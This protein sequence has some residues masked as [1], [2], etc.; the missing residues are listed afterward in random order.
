[1]PLWR[2]AT[3][4]TADEY[5]LMLRRNKLKLPRRLAVV[6]LLAIAA[7]LAVFAFGNHEDL[8]QQGSEVQF[9]APSRLMVFGAAT[10]GLGALFLVVAAIAWMRNR[11]QRA[12]IP[13]A[14]A[15]RLPSA[16]ARG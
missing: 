3:D 15:H 13:P 5:E 7:G 1:M 16:G 2:R 8:L 11:A 6:G 9:Q 10:A 12:A 4:L 14:R